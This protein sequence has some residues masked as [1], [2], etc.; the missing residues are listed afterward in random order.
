MQG[1]SD[2]LEDR[3]DVDERVDVGELI[4][5]LAAERGEPIDD[6]GRHRALG[7]GP[8]STP[9][10]AAAA[11]PAAAAARPRDVPRGVGA[12]AAAGDP[13]DRPQAFGVGAGAP[14]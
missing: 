13:G 2:D 11:H 3:L 5:R 7:D 6:A 14:R 9:G 4:A 10:R 12:V 1:T 8:R